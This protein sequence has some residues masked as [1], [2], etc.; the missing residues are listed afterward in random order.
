MCDT[1]KTIAFYI[2][3]TPNNLSINAIPNP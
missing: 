2:T 1:T 3:N